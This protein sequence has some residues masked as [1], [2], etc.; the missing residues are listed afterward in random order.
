MSFASDTFSQFIRQ[1]NIEQAITSSKQWPGEVCIKFIKCIIK[2]GFDNNNDVNLAL[3]QI[4]SMPKGPGL[5]SPVMLLLNR[6]IRGLL[7]QMNR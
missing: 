3:L 1:M 5:P 4:R 7:H 6:P 2:K